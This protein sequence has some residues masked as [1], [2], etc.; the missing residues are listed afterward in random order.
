MSLTLYP[1]TLYVRSDEK[2]GENFLV[3]SAEQEAAHK[4]EDRIKPSDMVFMLKYT[5]SEGLQNDQVFV[6]A[7]R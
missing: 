5:M 3:S 4:R 6:Y 1:N 7:L 2:L